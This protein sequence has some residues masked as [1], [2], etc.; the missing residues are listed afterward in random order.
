MNI[1]SSNNSI[2]PVKLVNDG[3]TGKQRYFGGQNKNSV[4]RLKELSQEFE[5]FFVG[6]MLKNMRSTIKKSEMFHGGMGEDVFQE[7]LDETYAENA[8]KNGGFGIG[9]MLF[10]EFK[11][12][13]I[14]NSDRNQ[15]TEK[16]WQNLNRQRQFVSLVDRAPEPSK[17]KD[18]KNIYINLKNNK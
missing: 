8:S 12:T 5:S 9:E 10:D 11:K 15:N 14:D 7:M 18:N 4:K 2:S 17:F 6:K 3:L 1:G 16:E 13:I